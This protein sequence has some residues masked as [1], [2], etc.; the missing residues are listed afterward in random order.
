MRK[1][2]VLN[3]NNEEPK[4]E[5]LLN[6]SKSDAKL[7]FLPIRRSSDNNPHLSISPS[8][9]LINA[10][11]ANNSYKIDSG[12]NSITENSSIA[13][14]DEKKLYPIKSSKAIMLSTNT[15][16]PIKISK[17]SYL[18]LPTASTSGNKGKRLSH[19]N[20]FK[21]SADKKLSEKSVTTTLDFSNTDT[22]YCNTDY[23]YQSLPK[24]GCDEKKLNCLLLIYNRT[25][26]HYKNK[27]FLKWKKIKSMEANK[28]NEVSSTNNSLDRK[29]KMKTKMQALII[30]YTSKSMSDYFSKWKSFPKID[31]VV[32]ENNSNN[33]NGK[34]SPN[35]N[36]CVICQNCGEDVVVP[37]EFFIEH[38]IEGIPEQSIKLKTKKKDKNYFAERAISYD[39]NFE[40]VVEEVEEVVEIEETEEIIA[41]KPVVSQKIVGK[42]NKI[43]KVAVNKVTNEQTKNLKKR[44]GGLT[45]LKIFMQILDP[46]RYYL[47]KWADGDRLLFIGKQIQTLKAKAV[48]IKVPKPEDPKPVVDSNEILLPLEPKA[49]FLKKELAASAEPI[50]ANEDKP[51]PSS[52]PPIKPKNNAVIATETIASSLYPEP[53]LTL[54]FVSN[55]KG[56]ISEVIEIKEKTDLIAEKINTVRQ[57][58]SL[59]KIKLNVKKKDNSSTKIPKIEEPLLS[60]GN[61]SITSNSSKK[62]LYLLKRKELLNKIVQR[63]MYFNEDLSVLGRYYN[64]WYKNLMK[65]KERKKKKIKQIVEVTTTTVEIR[66]RDGTPL[67]SEELKKKSEELAYNFNHNQGTFEVISLNVP[68]NKKYIKMSKVTNYMLT[69]QTKHKLLAKLAIKRDIKLY[70]AKWKSNAICSKDG[71]NFK[72]NPTNNHILYSEELK[73]YHRDKNKNKSYGKTVQVAT[74]YGNDDS[75]C[76]I[77]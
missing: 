23:S 48:A 6:L 56:L 71:L 57:V 17:N 13:S 2:Y 40:E 70:F 24:I 55:D 51:T 27:S 69:T 43:I 29:E 62:N 22:T 50:Q 7:N 36:C 30:Q 10:I 15:K 21:R 32:I 75:K 37:P 42:S 28:N 3:I 65:L 1:N 74:T 16:L 8:N 52:R 44:V 54:N 39:E 61:T 20:I 77:Y 41:G 66:R 64:K 5:N 18:K 60:E 4:N 38:G 14:I 33:N 58:N 12:S 34:S 46:L 49:D 63:K 11:S 73:E 31:L 45:E 25:T 9:P 19:E 26:L 47:L 72:L 53:E 76:V 59:K 68:S 67:T 35:K